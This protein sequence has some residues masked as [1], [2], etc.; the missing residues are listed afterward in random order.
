MLRYFFFDIN[1]F[2]ILLRVSLTC[3]TLLKTKQNKNK[4]GYVPHTTHRGII[5]M[6]RFVKH[7]KN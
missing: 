3:I 6:I 2:V 5:S 1:Q 4:G 7:N